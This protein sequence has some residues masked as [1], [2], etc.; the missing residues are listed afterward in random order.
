MLEHRKIV[1]EVPP[2]E[3]PKYGAINTL[4][5]MTSESTDD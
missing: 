5:V 3:R 4:M 2:E 1:E